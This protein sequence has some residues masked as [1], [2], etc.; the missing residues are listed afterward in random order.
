VAVAGDIEKGFAESDVTVE[1]EFS[2]KM[3]HQGYIEPQAATAMWNADGQVS[4]WTC[5]QGSFPARQNCSAILGIP[6]SKIKV[7][8]TEIGGGFGGKIAVYLEPFAALLSKK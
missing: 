2:T 4:I 3:V 5:T 6:I 7:T 1:G 8:P